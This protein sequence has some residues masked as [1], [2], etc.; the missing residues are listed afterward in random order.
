MQTTRRPTPTLPP[1]ITGGPLQAPGCAVT[2]LVEG[3][4][5]HIQ[6]T[7]E[8]GTTVDPA[9]PEAMA[10]AADVLNAAIIWRSGQRSGHLNDKAKGRNVLMTALHGD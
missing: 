1:Y 3:G 7:N 10:W 2:F 5:L 8:L 9:T 6:R 4:T